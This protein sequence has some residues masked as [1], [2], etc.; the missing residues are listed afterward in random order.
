MAPE[1]KKEIELEIAHVYLSDCCTIRTACEATNISQTSFFEWIRRG[2]AG[3][4]P[5]AQFAQ[6]VTRARANG[7]IALVRQILADKDWRAKAWYLERCWADEFGRTVE[8]PLP[9]RPPE[10]PP[11]LS[12]SVKLEVPEALV[13]Q[14]L[15]D[16]ARMAKALDKLPA[17]G[18]IHPRTGVITLADGTVISPDDSEP[19]TEQSQNA[20]DV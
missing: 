17:G 13:Q 2:E 15:E 20:A 1:V 8:R 12:K 16:N 11:D 6:A 4:R 7:K 5:F 14:M 3:E 9:P 10:P 19:R 18:A